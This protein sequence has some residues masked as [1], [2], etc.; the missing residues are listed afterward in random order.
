MRL[1]RLAALA[2][3]GLALAAAGGIAS[4]TE[5]Q[6]EDT[7]GGAAAS[8]EQAGATADEEEKQ[9]SE[10]GEAKKAAEPKRRRFPL[11]NRLRAKRTPTG[12]K[13][14]AREGGAKA[15]EPA[16]PRPTA[17]I[18]PAPAS[19]AEGE[20]APAP[21][22]P[23]PPPRQARPTRTGA[24]SAQAPPSTTRPP[25][26]LPGSLGRVLTQ[27]SITPLAADPEVSRRIETIEG[28]DFDPDSLNDF[29]VLLGRRGYTPAAISVQEEAVRRAPKSPLF[30]LNLG[31]LHRDAGNSHLA[32][33]DYRKAASLD[34]LNALAHY[35]LGAIREARGD[36]DAAVEL[37]KKA[38]RLDPSLADPR[39]NPQV[40][41][42]QLLL[43]VQLQL[44]QEKAGALGLPLIS[45]SATAPAAEKRAREPDERARE[46]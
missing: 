3:L 27:L 23:A 1:T 7:A 45:A 22:P 35:N 25:R 19:A 37:Y 40:V 46:P 13:E 29:A 14:A 31:T 33:R 10:D 15:A 26:G 43:A 4:A 18:P 12:G 34:P 6:Q 8:D 11:F 38:L 2:V 39:H 42:S 44:Y 21:R 17:A 16:P 9:E 5:E 41:N 28:G 30:W 24:A 32:E 20:P 36:Y